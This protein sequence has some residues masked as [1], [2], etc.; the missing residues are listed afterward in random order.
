MWMQGPRDDE[1]VQ[2]LD[3]YEQLVDNFAQQAKA[4]WRLWGRWANRWSAASRLG[5]RANACGCDKF[6]EQADSP[7]LALGT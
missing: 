5:R 2:G 4:Y 6:M 1:A 3:G 7:N